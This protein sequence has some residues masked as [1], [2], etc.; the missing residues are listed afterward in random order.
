MVA[1]GAIIG[2]VHA[3]FAFPLGGN[4]RAIE[5]DRTLLGS[6]LVLCLVGADEK[7]DDPTNRDMKRIQGTW[8]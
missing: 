6:L 8:A 4:Q 3:G 1:P 2:D 7:R 5:V